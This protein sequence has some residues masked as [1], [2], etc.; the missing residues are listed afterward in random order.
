MNNF[1]SVKFLATSVIYLCGSLNTMSSNPQE[2]D[3]AEFEVQLENL[4]GMIE[5]Q[6]NNKIFTGRDN[7][8]VD[9]LFHKLESAEKQLKEEEDK[10]NRAA[11]AKVIQYKDEIANLKKEIDHNIKQGFDVVTDE[12]VGSL[13]HRTVNNFLEVAKKMTGQHSIFRDEKKLMLN[14]LKSSSK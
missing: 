12:M 13:L 6:K 11:K 1:T 9:A 3:R 7:K 8:K 4:K 14:W 5:N 2:V 10:G